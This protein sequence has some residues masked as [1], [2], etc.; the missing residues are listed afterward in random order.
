MSLLTRV[1]SW[2]V[3]SAILNYSLTVS[4]ILIY[5]FIYFIVL[6]VAVMDQM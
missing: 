3:P 1:L 2:M 6:D 5:L 4:L